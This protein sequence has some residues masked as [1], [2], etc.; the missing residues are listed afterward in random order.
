MDV[1]APSRCDMVHYL[2]VVAYLGIVAAAQIFLASPRLH[3]ALGA[4]VYH[5]AK[6]CTR[7]NPQSVLLAGLNALSLPH[8]LSTLLKNGNVVGAA[9]RVAIIGIC[10][11]KIF[12]VVCP[13]AAALRHK[14]RK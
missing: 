4:F 14:G 5:V 1:R 13:C 6:P 12:H 11:G 8:A 10:V 9:E 7:D 3:L 2:G